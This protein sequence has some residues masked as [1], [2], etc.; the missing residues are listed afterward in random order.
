MPYLTTD[1]WTDEHGIVHPKGEV[2][3]VELITNPL[4]IVNRTIPMAL[5]EPSITFVLDK[6]RKYMKKLWDE[7]ESNS[8]DKKININDLK[9]IEEFLFG[10]MSILN[11]KQTK[12]LKKLYKS[13]SERNKREFVKDSISINDQGL[14]NTNNGIYVQ[15]EA[16]SEDI[17]LR[18]AL[19]EIYEKYE[20]IIE[21]YNIFMPK[22]KWGRDIYLGKDCVGYQYILLLKQSGERGFSVRSAGAINDES[23]PEKSHDNKIGKHWSSETPIRFGEYETPNFQIITHPH[24]F[25]LVTALYRSSVDGRKFMYEAILSKD[26]EYNIPKEFTSRSAE[27][28]QVYL[29]SLGVKMETILD[30]AN[31]IGTKE[32]DEELVGYSIYN[33]TIFCTPNEWYYLDKLGKLYKRY[34][35]ENPGNIDEITDIWDYIYKNFKSVDLKKKDLTDNIIKLFNDNIEAF[36]NY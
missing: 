20:N 25:A 35:K 1:T 15:W 36:S 7:I 19:I 26:G 16:F 24:D 5:Y 29:K 33:K 27:I 23:L 21:P 6:A 30:D 11:P 32:H 22:P 18:D 28:L 10:L 17:N 9:E 2:E 13:L 31:Y 3:R 12:H 8:N 4:A 34:R 14:I